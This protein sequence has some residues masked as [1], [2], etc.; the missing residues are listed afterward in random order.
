MACSHDVA[1]RLLHSGSS[2]DKSAEVAS[3]SISIRW[4]AQMWPLQGTAV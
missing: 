3:G 2:H 1:R 4:P